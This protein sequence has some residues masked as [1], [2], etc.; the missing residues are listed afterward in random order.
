VGAFC[1]LKRAGHIAALQAQAADEFKQFDL[2]QLRVVV[3]FG[4]K[5]QAGWR[6]AQPP[7][8]VPVLEAPHPSG[9]WL[10][11][12]PEDRGVIVAALREARRL[13]YTD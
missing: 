2:P 10:N 12:H 8:D 9:R 7:V 4:R 6:R 11:A 1:H 13:A 5:A 3:L